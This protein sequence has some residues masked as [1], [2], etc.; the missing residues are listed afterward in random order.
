MGAPQFAGDFREF[1]K[2]LVSADAEFM[3]IGGYAVAFHGFPRNT[4]D[5]D[6]W[7]RPTAENASRVES[8]ASEF[9]I[10]V[11]EGGRRALRDANGMIRMGYPPLR[12]ELLTGP[13]GVEWDAC[14]GRVVRMAVGDLSVPVIAL[15][16]LLV[17]KLA[18]GRPRDL[19]DVQELRRL[20]GR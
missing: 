8:A 12:I 7:V 10:P 17:N 9:G 1:L 20:H 6:I 18:A 2:S 15:E 11:T 13:S 16:D 14:F 5:L 3:V 19:L 4:G